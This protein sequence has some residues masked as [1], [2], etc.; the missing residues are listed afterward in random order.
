MES[1]ENQFV[2][3]DFKHSIVN[4]AATLEQFLGKKPKHAVLPKLAEKLKSD[5]KNVVYIVI[6]A[7]GSK[8]L[9]KN[10]PTNSFL[11][12]HQIDTVTS[13]FPS[14]TTAATTSLITAMTP[15][16]HG[17]FAWVVDFNGEVIE[18]FRNRNYY[19][20][21][22]TA[23]PDFAQH[24][25]PYEKIFDDVHNDRAIYTC[26]PDNISKIHSPHEIEFHTIGQMFR[27]LKQICRQPD[28]KFVYA[29]CDD[30]DGTMHSYGTTARQSKNLIRK[31][32]RK[33][34]R[35]AKH[36]PDTLFVITADHGQIDVQGF[37][38]FCDDTELQSCLA[39]PISLDPRGAC[40]KLKP[41]KDR[42]FRAA[43]QKYEPDFALFPSQELIQK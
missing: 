16:E 2:W 1:N 12:Q 43:F 19:T 14:T 13:V 34:A 10:L 6:D 3:P 29:Y 25:L 37:A 22:F 18:L 28:K 21:E 5:Y 40:F 33:V 4:L 35:L 20:H 8:I 30:L 36:N 9:E 17:W 15:A 42:A 32:E 41:G 24:K 7:M 39:H 38:Y 11:R 27:R 26:L 31:I 23:D